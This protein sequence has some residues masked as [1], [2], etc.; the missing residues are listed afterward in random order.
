M[1]LYDTTPPFTD[2]PFV[3]NGSKRDGVDESCDDV[4]GNRDGVNH[5]V[6]NTR[7][8]HY[9]CLNGVRYD[10]TTGVKAHEFVGFPIADQ[11]T[12]F[13]PINHWGGLTGIDLNNLAWSIL[14]GTNPSVPHVSVPTIIGELKDLPSLVKVRGDGFLRKVAQSHLSWR[15]A[16][17]P[18][19]SD[20]RK[21]C[22]FA[23]AFDN[24]LA[25]LYSLRDGRVMKR[26]CH[27]GRSEA[28]IGA[29]TN[30]WY[31]AGFG[32]LLQGPLHHHLVKEVWG[33]A[34]WKLAPD[35]MLPQMG[36]GPLKS[37]A[38]RLNYGITS[39]EALATAWE[40]TPWSWLIDWFSNIGD[41]IA[42]TNNS[43]DLHWQ[44]ICVMRRM[45]RNIDAKVDRSISTPW[46]T[47]DS[48]YVLWYERKERYP[49]TP[50]LPFPFPTLP[51]IDGGK[52]SILASLAALRLLPG[53]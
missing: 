7:V 46:I 26:R 13:D 15:W 14:A 17:R 9:P 11:I 25:E 35:A 31:H 51:I 2:P 16:V 41:V 47:L 43:L 19:L 22:N 30:H 23:R 49:C 20:L 27:L 38:N 36:F 34:Q 40:L 52:M 39:H 8:T 18:M 4:V 53:A 3:A 5:F 1:Y 10:P 6:K 29:E 45:F 42:A 21:L 33:T 50:V 32:V 24:R 48:D 28:I 44:K 12:V 37:L